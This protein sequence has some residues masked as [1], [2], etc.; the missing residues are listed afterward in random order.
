MI[1]YISKPFRWFFKLEAASGLVL[2]FAAIIALF[3]SNSGLA[4]LYFATL[5]KYLFIGINNIGLKLSVLH[6]INDA[7]MAIFF[8]FVTLEIKREFLQGELSNIKQALLPII[9]AV[10]GMLVPALFYV[11]INLGDSETL[12]GW[13]IPSATD[14]AFSLGVLSLLGKRV[15]LSLKVFLTALAIIDDLGA[16]VIIALFYSGDL[17]IKYLTLMLLAFIVLLLINNFN[18]K[19]FLP[20]LVVGL[21][22][23]DFTHNSGIHATIAGVLLAMTI[24][25]RKKDKDFSLLIKIEHAISPYV[26]FGIMPLFAFANAGVSLEGLSFASLLDKVPLG[27]VLGLFLGKQFGVFVFSYVSIKLKVAQMPN[28]TS[29]YNFYGVGVL[30]GIGFTMSLFVGNLAFLENMQYMDGVKIGVLTGSLLSTLFGY[31]LILLTP[32]KPKK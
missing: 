14:I 11:F 25:H 19:K 24:P 32:N 5:N 9:A 22:L 31:F 8:F 6:W 20:Y 2:L 1:N 23:W 18:I 30:T 7:L 12:N 28:D 3:I 29:W 17:S 4:D 27:I 15:P 21:F 13:A 16:I 26:A 10:G